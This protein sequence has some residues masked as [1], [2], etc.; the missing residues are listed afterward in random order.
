[1]FKQFILFLPLEA[2]S[3]LGAARALVQADAHC[4]YE[5][6]RGNAAELTVI[7]PTSESEA[8]NAVRESS[9][10]LTMPLGLS[11]DHWQ[12]VDQHRPDTWPSGDCLLYPCSPRT[13]SFLEE[14]TARPWADVCAYLSLHV[15]RRQM[16]VEALTAQ[17]WSAGELRTLLCSIPLGEAQVDTERLSRLHEGTR[18]L[19]EHVHA[20]QCLADTTDPLVRSDV[21]VAHRLVD[22][23]RSAMGECGGL[24]KAMAIFRQVVQHEDASATFSPAYPRPFPLGDGWRS[25]FRFIIGGESFETVPTFP[26]PEPELMG[27]ELLE[28]PVQVDGKV[29]A[30][31][32]VERRAFDNQDEL[33]KLALGEDNVRAHLG[34]KPPRSVRVVSFKIVSFERG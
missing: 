6:T 31:L 19:L 25:A 26:E 33:I 9:A 8:A 14:R 18:K 23:V 10:A 13:W 11:I 32:N 12:E 17:G 22:G 27:Q 28:I 21:A 29:R 7:Y 5:R 3:T 30:R 15:D 20:R 24:A 4:R 16:D 1:M 2:G 34:E